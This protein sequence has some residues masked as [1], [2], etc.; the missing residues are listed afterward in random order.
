MQKLRYVGWLSFHP[1][2]RARDRQFLTK[3]AG[4]SLCDLPLFTTRGDGRA[5]PFST[6]IYSTS[7]PLTLCIVNGK[8]HHR[9]AQKSA[10]RE[11]DNCVCVRG[12][13]YGKD[14]HIGARPGV[15]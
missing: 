6:S 2:L 13:L 11:R 3:A 15:V 4:H 10:E 12:N 5:S 1:H 7:S 8:K 9:E 14:S